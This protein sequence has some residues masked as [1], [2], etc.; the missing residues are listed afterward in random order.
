MTTRTTTGRNRRLAAVVAFALLVASMIFPLW[1]TRMEAPQYRGDEQLQ[2]YV[3]S[4]RVVGD[5]RELS[6]LNQ[7]VG[8]E[9]RLDGPE[10]RGAPWAFGLL[11]VIAAIATVLPPARSRVAS[12]IVFAGLALTLLS[13][14]A[15]L[16][17]RLYE[18]GHNRGHTALAGVEDFTA[19]I[20]GSKKI[21]NFTVHTRPEAGGWALLAALAMSGWGAFA[22][23]SPRTRDLSD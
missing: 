19:P 7:Y 2:V 20:L 11:S 21:A 14:A 15:I 4:N 10:L 6:T 3:Y 5:L 17:Y 23:P 13:G 18:M 9:L 16:Q 8:V 1:S 22:S 12:R